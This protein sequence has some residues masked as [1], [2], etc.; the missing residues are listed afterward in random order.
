[1]DRDREMSYA[2]RP[3][4][5]YSLLHDGRTLRRKQRIRNDTQMKK[6]T[7]TRP[8]PHHRNATQRC[9]FLLTRCA[10]CSPTSY[11]DTSHAVVPS[12]QGGT[13]ITPRLLLFLCL[14][15]TPRTKRGSQK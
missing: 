5:K 2:T 4:L 11:W 14:R 9:S 10:S 12:G 1:M 3:C 8:L 6:R 7:N 15:N 13:R